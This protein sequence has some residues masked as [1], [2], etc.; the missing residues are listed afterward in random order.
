M[1][2]HG[3]WSLGKQAKATDVVEQ[4][5]VEIT[6]EPDPEPDQPEL[7]LEDPEV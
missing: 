3:T 5:P 7:P 1:G 4:P 2:R 6:V